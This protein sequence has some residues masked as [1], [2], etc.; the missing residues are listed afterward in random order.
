MDNSDL[1]LTDQKT[2]YLQEL[3]ALGIK[4]VK[5]DELILDLVVISA[6][7]NSITTN[8]ENLNIELTWRTRTGWT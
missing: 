8:L 3:T 7:Q 4:D 6:S 1:D 5:E 2:K